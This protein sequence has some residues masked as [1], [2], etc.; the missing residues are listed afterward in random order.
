MEELKCSAEAIEEAT[1][2]LYPEK[3]STGWGV[4]VPYCLGGKDPLD[5]VE[6]YLN[7]DND[8]PYWHYITYGFSELYDEEDDDEFDDDE[9]NEDDDD[10]EIDDDNEF[11]EDEINDEVLAEE[12]L[13]GYGFELSFRLK[14]TSEEPPIWPVNLLQNLARYV[15]SSGYVFDDGHHLNCNGPIALETD[16]KI[17]ALLFVNDTE[18]GS[19]K[20]TSGKV[21]FLQVVGITCAEL[22]AIMY[23]N[24]NMFYNELEKYV[25]LGITDLERDCLMDNPKFYKAWEEG[26]ERDGSSTG[27]L[28]MNEFSCCLKDNQVEIHLGAGHINKFCTMLKARVCKDRPLYINVKDVTYGFVLGEENGFGHEEAD[29]CLVKL[30][31]ATVEDLIEIV[32]PHKGE[33]VSKL[34]PIKFV[35]HPTEIRDQAG[36]VVEV[37]E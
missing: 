5:F 14:K 35:V 26:V 3:E 29:F 22:D 11:D 9:L 10:E 15:F 30:T 31:L 13:S 16:T 2:A 25:P 19:I 28:F 6:V 17:E 1:K 21:N 24:G 33:Y 4:Q 7:D 34:A 8:T 32:K 23:W 37:I 20:T 27:S 36:N 18:L 12:K